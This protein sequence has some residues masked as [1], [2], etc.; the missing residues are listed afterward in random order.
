MIRTAK[1]SEKPDK[2]NIIFLKQNSSFHCLGNCTCVV[3]NV[4]IGETSI[5]CRYD[6]QL[7]MMLAQRVHFKSNQI[8]VRK[9]G[10]NIQ[11]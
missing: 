11:Y 5:I 6:A 8:N 1:N 9:L 2:L 3:V 10:Q 4:F 7:V